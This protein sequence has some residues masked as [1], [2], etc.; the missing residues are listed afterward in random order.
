[1]TT[2][3]QWWAER[4]H[5]APSSG[6]V[7]FGGVQRPGDVVTEQAALVL[8]VLGASL[9]SGCCSRFPL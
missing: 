7:G 1:M 6:C 4:M 8:C 5:C 3:T 2:E 9:G